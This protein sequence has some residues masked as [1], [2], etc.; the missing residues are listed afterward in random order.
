M[1][2][3]DYNTCPAQTLSGVHIVFKYVIPPQFK[4]DLDGKTG[5]RLQKI[6][7]QPA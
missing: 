6:A 4:I 3:E 2:T 7:Q 1:N 5:Q